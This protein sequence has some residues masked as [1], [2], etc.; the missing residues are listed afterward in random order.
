MAGVT[1]MFPKTYSLTLSKLFQG[2]SLRRI[3]VRIITSIILIVLAI[4]LFN[5]Q[6]ISQSD[7]KLDSAKVKN[8]FAKNRCFSKG[9]IGI[10]DRDLYIVVKSGK[11][12]KNELILSAG[13]RWTGLSVGTPEVVI[14]YD[15]NI[16]SRQ[17]L[18]D[19]FN[20]SKAVVISFE[21]DKVRFF[22]F[23]KMEGGYYDRIWV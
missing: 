20:L 18:P 2:D 9:G 13:N 19:G 1:P 7:K 15:N 16:W 21:S 17:T 4:I 22:D 10:I 14:F 6:G 12:D 3:I 11:N 8:M 23:R 5:V